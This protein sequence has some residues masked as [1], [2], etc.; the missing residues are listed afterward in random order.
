M[1]CAEFCFDAIEAEQEMK[2]AKQKRYN[3]ALT[4]W[5]VVILMSIRHSHHSADDSLR[6]T[7][8][9]RWREEVQKQK[10]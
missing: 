7:V 3:A 9:I 2:K 1:I 4:I 6:A 5:R 10:K 8:I